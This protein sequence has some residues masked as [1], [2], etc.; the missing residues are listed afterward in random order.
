MRQLHAVSPQAA[1]H[2]VEPLANQTVLLQ[3]VPGPPHRDLAW[4]AFLAQ[5]DA[6]CRRIT[7]ESYSA[8]YHRIGDRIPLLQ[9]VDAQHLLQPDRASA[10]CAPLRIIRVARC[11][12]RAQR[13]RRHH[14]PH[15]Y[16]GT[17]RTTSA[18]GAAQIQRSAALLGSF[19]WRSSGQSIAGAGL[20]P[21]GKVSVSLMTSGK[22]RFGSP[23]PGRQ[24]RESWESW[25]SLYRTVSL[26]TPTLATRPNF[27]PIATE[28]VP[29]W[30]TPSRRTS[31]HCIKHA[32][33]R[34]SCTGNRDTTSRRI[35]R[36]A[37]RR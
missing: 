7:A 5:V 21:Q 34:R 4:C 3:Q 29:R 15:L 14:L 32:G 1:G 26:G 23:P 37:H 30:Q 18:C 2:W 11:D 24:P 36:N 6:T 35:R 10:A 31:R 9:G 22:S 12:T 8:F 28:A 25:F 19:S 17:R 20:R 13:R 27:N 33:H 16:R